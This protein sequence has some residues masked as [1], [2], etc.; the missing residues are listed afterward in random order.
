MIGIQSVPVGDVI[1]EYR[2]THAPANGAIPVDQSDHRSRMSDI[3][4]LFGKHATK[5]FILLNYLQFEA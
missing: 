3:G 5:N 4:Y 2:L 1:M